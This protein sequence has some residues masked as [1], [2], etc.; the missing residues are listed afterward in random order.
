[1]LSTFLNPFL[2]G[3]LGHDPCRVEGGIEAYILVFDGPGACL[4]Q[5]SSLGYLDAVTD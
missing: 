4:L 5:N 3:L 1:M 2:N